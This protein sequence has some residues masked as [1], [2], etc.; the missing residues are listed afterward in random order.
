MKSEYI[1]TDN[2][3]KQDTKKSK[4]KQGNQEPEKEK[5]K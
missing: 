1:Q 2:I 4:K 3:E 5:K